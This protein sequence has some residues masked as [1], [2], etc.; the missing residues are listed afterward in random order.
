MTPPI[1]EHKAWQEEKGEKTLEARPSSGAVGLR[2]AAGKFQVDQMSTQTSEPPL[3]HPGAFALRP[4]QYTAP[5]QSG[6]AN[7][8]QWQTT[9]SST[10]QGWPYAGPV[11]FAQPG[12]GLPQG[13]Y[14]LP[15][16]PM[17]WP[18]G[19]SGVFAG[20]NSTLGSMN[21]AASTPFFGMYPGQPVVSGYPAPA[22]LPF[23]ADRS[24]STGAVAAAPACGGSQAST[25]DKESI[26]TQAAATSL[27]PP[28]IRLPLPNEEN[29]QPTTSHADT[30]K[31]CAGVRDITMASTF[32]MEHRTGGVSMSTKTQPSSINCEATEG[33]EATEE[34]SEATKEGSEATEEGSEATGNSKATEGSSRS[35][36]V[37][38]SAAQKSS[39]PVGAVESRS[40]TGSSGRDRSEMQEVDET[41]ARSPSPIWYPAGTFNGRGSR[42][43]ALADPER[44]EPFYDHT[45]TP[46]S[47][48]SGPSRSRSSSLTELST[49][50]GEE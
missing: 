44:R 22:V 10:S 30:S 26:I 4:S 43:P 21:P 25:M 17:I 46:V 23:G 34:G 24:V 1:S 42:E 49:R 47:R 40:E 7:P 15:I 8:A 31:A 28:S 13:P 32:H 5:V 39:H 11:F 37:R 35:E 29:V 16:G 38:H 6:Y 33:T 27:A 14:G 19:P 2:T 3:H 41:L 45:H 50:D 9:Y 12:Y 36:D 18:V 48:V 20:M